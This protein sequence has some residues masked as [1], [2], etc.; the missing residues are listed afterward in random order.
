[1]LAEELDSGVQLM[2]KKSEGMFLYFHYAAEAILEKDVLTLKDLETLLPDGIDDYYEQ[3]FRRLHTRLG[4]EKYQLLFQAITAA[5]S[6]FPLELVCPLLKVEHSEA[7][8]IIDAV[9]VLLPIVNDCL[10][11]FHKSVKDW[12]VDEDLAE[13]LVVNPIAGHSQVALL[14]YTKLKKLKISPVSIS[15]LVGKPI[16]KYAIDNLVYHLSKTTRKPDDIMKLCDTV[17]DLQYIYYRLH[18]SQRSTKYLLDDI[19]EAKRL[20]QPRT[21]LNK[22]LELSANFLYRHAH[23]LSTYPHL[24]FQC[25]LNEPWPIA[26]QLGIQNYT[27]S[28]ADK[29]PGLH[30]YLEL[31]NKPQNFAPALTE[32]HCTNDVIS[33]D[34]S[35][36]GQV[37]ACTDAKTRVYA[38]N[39]LTGELMCN[40]TKKN[41]V[42]HSYLTSAVFRQTEKKY[43]QVISLK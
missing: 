31:I 21:E 12:L 8:Q 16:H 19:A 9:S 14:C 28:P 32:Y 38:W 2:V 42:S 17:M 29:F 22:K 7:L 30:V 43:L 33:F 37:I 26:M 3:N 35:H 6:D 27:D 23:I 39:K 1:M 36:D 15:E 34:Y 10:T 13:D 11:I 24:I 41:T 18:T 4:K 20:V 25:A 40:L 5:R